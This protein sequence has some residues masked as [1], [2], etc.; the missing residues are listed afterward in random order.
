MSLLALSSELLIIILAE[1][2]VEDVISV[3][4]THPDLYQISFHSLRSRRLDLRP[5]CT[6]GD[7]FRVRLLLQPGADADNSSFHFGTPLS[8]AAANGREEVVKLLLEHGARVDHELHFK[9]QPLHVA[10]KKG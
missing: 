2:E 1:L 5:Y 10:A 6:S 7:I 8:D 9:H 3:L 4:E